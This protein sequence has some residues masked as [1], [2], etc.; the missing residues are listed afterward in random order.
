MKQAN[1]FVIIQIKP[2]NGSFLRVTLDEKLSV[3]YNV[4]IFRELCFI[5]FTILS[6]VLF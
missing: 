3:L 5:F 2:L 4:L 1:I 6:G